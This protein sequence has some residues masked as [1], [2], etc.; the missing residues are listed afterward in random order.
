M[1]GEI[2]ANEEMATASSPRDGG[3]EVHLGIRGNG[4]E[5]TGF[6]NAGS[7]RDGDSRFEPISVTET[8]THA[9]ETDFEF[10]DDFSNRASLDRE[11]PDVS[12]QS[13]QGGRNEDFR[14]RGYG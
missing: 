13:S 5:Q 12:G 8:I 6:A 3:E 10:V 2:R 11:G 14:H 7:D 4:L 9:G 1:S